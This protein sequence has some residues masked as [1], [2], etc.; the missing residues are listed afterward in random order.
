MSM[1]LLNQPIKK[2]FLCR[3]LLHNP[4]GCRER[5]IGSDSPLSVQPLEQMGTSV[6][7]IVG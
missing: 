1:T 4:F 7:G 2:F 5:P 3:F 6:V